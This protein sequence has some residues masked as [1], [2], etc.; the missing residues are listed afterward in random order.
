VSGLV[1]RPVV[2]MGNIPVMNP[3]GFPRRV[4]ENPVCLAGIFLGIGDGDFQFLFTSSPREG[5]ICS[6][7]GKFSQGTLALAHGNGWL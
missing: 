4:L 5:A 7:L 3:E 6:G 2:G 1:R